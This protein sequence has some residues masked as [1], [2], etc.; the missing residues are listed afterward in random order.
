MY[1]D[2]GCIY[3]VSCVELGKAW[4]SMTHQMMLLR[5][6]PASADAEYALWDDVKDPGLN[7]QVVYNPQE[8]IAA[9]FINVG[10][11]PKL[12]VMREQGSNSQLEMAWA[13]DQAGFEVIDLPMTDLL[14]GRRDLSDL[15]GLVAAGGFSYG[16]VLGAGQGW[17]R[18]IR[19]NAMLNEQF[20]EFFQ[21]TDT[22]ALGVCNGCQM[23]AALAP[24]IPGRNTGLLLPPTN[25]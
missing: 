20:A 22:F 18:T 8:N 14:S 19:F 1:R 23:M 10:A 5:D 6:N 4:S 16:D 15:K 13:F 3:Q 12:A 24:M 7:A 17:A 25:P 9:S 2:G 11:R 21:R